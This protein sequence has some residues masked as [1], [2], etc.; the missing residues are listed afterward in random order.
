MKKTLVALAA[1]AAVSAFAQVTITGRANVGVTYNNAVAPGAATVGLGAGDN[2]RINFGVTEDLGGGMA[3]VFNAQMRFNP[4]TG[5]TE[6]TSGSRP[7]FQ[8]ETRVGLR[9]AFGS[10]MLGRGLTAL[11]A[12]NGGM[13]DPFGVST[14]AGSIYAPGFATDYAAGGEG[15]MEGIWYSSP[16]ISGFQGSVSFSPATTVI[17]GTAPTTANGTAATYSKT[18]YSTALTYVAGPINAVVGIE[19]NRYGDTLL[20]VGGNYDLG[21][22][23]LYAG[24]G[25]VRGGDA[26]MKTGT[27]TFAATSSAYPG[28]SAASVVGNGAVL[29]GSTNTVWS[30]GAAIPMGATTIRAGYSSYSSDL[31]NAKRDSKLGLGM[32]YALSSRTFI[33]SDL[34]STTRNNNLTGSNPGANDSTVTQF[35]FGI[36]HNF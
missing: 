14:V 35:D 27:P 13:I 12:P 29:A 34:A 31:V 28:A 33:Y 18:A 3:A 17:A 36:N 23:K 11:Q 22:A 2:N 21:A 6:G 16:V 5:G 20:N 7:L 19:E 4:T 26:A 9:G 24:Y 1:L 10:V 25:R 30:V 15:R 32:S 8:G